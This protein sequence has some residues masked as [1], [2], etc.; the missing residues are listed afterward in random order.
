MS[1]KKEFRPT[2]QQVEEMAGITAKELMVSIPNREKT[3]CL[4]GVPRGGVYAALLVS[5][6]LTD[7]SILSLLVDSLFDADAI[8]D[9]IVDSGN[10]QR[11]YY[12]TTNGTPF[13]ALYDNNF[14]NLHGFV[15][16][17]WLVLK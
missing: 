5:K 9:D 2:W 16:F 3:I 12:E 11:R 7:M 4:Y 17:P 14:T 6:A 13:K 1:K 10:T 8:I 15:V